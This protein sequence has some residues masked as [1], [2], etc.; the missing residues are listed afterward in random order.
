MSAVQSGRHKELG[1]PG[2]FQ[3]LPSDDLKGQ[4]RFNCCFARGLGNVLWQ[5]GAIPTMACEDLR[6]ACHRAIIVT[7]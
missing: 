6:M 2:K 1:R 4:L 3:L 5:D 7:R